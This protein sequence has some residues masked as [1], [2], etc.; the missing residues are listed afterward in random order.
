M[1]LKQPGVIPEG[2]EWIVVEDPN[3]I[4]RGFLRKIVRD[5]SAKA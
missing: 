1:N 2:Y 5:G 3:T 4:F